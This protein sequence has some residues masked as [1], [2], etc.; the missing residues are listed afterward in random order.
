MNWTACP[1]GKFGSRT[2][3]IEEDDCDA[4]IAG[5][6][7]SETALT[8]PNGNCTAGFY[9]PPGSENS[10]GKTVYAGNSTC[11]KG[12]Y[13]PAGSALP[14]A[15]PPGS[16]NPTL[17]LNKLSQCLDCLPGSYC[18]KYNLSHP[19]GICNPGY[20]CVRGA[21]VGN[22]TITYTNTN[23]GNT[24]GGGICP[25]ASYCSANTSSPIS[26]PAGTYNNRYH[27]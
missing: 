24:V 25:R 19:N 23:T 20:Y 4:C 18:S 5:Q 17:G 10:W 15:C 7:C 3:L 6:Y 27:L 9:C 16:Y 26:C 11:P 14:L 8:K 2:N 12:S 13:C 1:V 22:P 21:S